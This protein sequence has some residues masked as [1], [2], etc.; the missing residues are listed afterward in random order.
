M[1]KGLLLEG[2]SGPATVEVGDRLGGGRFGEVFAAMDTATNREF[3]VKFPQAA[4]VEAL[5]FKNDLLAAQRVHHRNVVAVLWTSAESTPPYIVME[6]VNGTNLLAEIDRRRAARELPTP[7]NLR[8]WFGDIVDGIEAINEHLLHR[9]IKPDN[10][11]IDGTGTLKI[12]DFGLAK[13]IDAATRTAT[14]KYV[15][16]LAYMAPEV[17]ERETNAIQRDMY[18]VGITLYEAA[19]LDYPLPLPTERTMDKWKRAHLGGRPKKLG[20]SR[21]DLPAGVERVLLKL[22]AKRP[23]D[24]FATWADVKREMKAAWSSGSGGAGGPS[25][26]RIIRALTAQRAARESAVGTASEDAERRDMLSQAI[27]YQWEMLATSIEEAFADV[28]DA[29]IVT[30]KRD[31]GR[32]ALDAEGQ[33]LGS[34][35]LENFSPYRFRNGNLSG[36]VA[37]LTTSCG[38]GFNAVLVRANEEDLYGEWKGIAW[39]H[40]AL[41]GRRDPHAKEPFGMSGGRLSTEL[42]YMQGLTG[43]FSIDLVGDI[44]GFFHRLVADCLEA[45]ARGDS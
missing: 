8:S 44:P 4:G 3:A 19:T 2:P 37:L 22:I 39:K 26:D 28:V 29:G 17:W 18:A 16:A 21:G 11:L 6:R 1:Q 38:Q 36:A 45:A 13:I 25:G 24:R 40:H 10:I 33:P 7:D 23:Q 32:L 20:D 15:G 31:V 43:E 5:A 14:F 30:I 35:H 9:D 27:S 42:R 12:A 41:Y 34:V